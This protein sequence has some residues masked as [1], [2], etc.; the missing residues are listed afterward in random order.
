MESFYFKFTIHYTKIVLCLDVK[1]YSPT[2]SNYMILKKTSLTILFNNFVI[3]V[4]HPQSEV[5]DNQLVS[6]NN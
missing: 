4:T 5:S 3:A 2:L 1:D 6:G